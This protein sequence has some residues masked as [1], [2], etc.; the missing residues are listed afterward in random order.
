MWLPLKSGESRPPLADSRI[1]SSTKTGL[2]ARGIEGFDE[3]ELT[4]HI[5]PGTQGGLYVDFLKQGMN[6]V[7]EEDM[8]IA[9]I[10]IVFATRT[11]FELGLRGSCDADDFHCESA[12]EMQIPPPC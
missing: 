1:P 9:T 4:P 2:I 10:V 6:S 8:A 7:A 3:Y 11:D 5:K 12:P